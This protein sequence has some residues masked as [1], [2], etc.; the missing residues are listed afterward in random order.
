[1]AQ[2]TANELKQVYP[3]LSALWGVVIG[4][5]VITILLIAFFDFNYFHS[6]DFLISRS[7][8][9]IFLFLRFVLKTDINQKFGI[10]SDTMLVYL[11]LAFFYGETAHFNTFLFPKID[12]FLV[13]CDEWLFGFQPSIWFSAKFNQAIFSELMFLGYFSYYIMPFIAFLI[14]WK[15]KRDFFEEFSFLV[16]SADFVYYIIFILLPA[17]GPQYFF[18]YPLCDI[19]AKGP[20]GA[21]IKLVQHLGEAPTAAFPSSHVG[22]MV[23]I[24]TLLFKEHKTLFKIFVP[25]S[26]TILFST[27]YIKAHYFVDVLAGLLSGPVILLINKYLFIKIKSLQKNTIYVNRN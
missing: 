3:K 6:P 15:Y 24:L 7:I 9:I 18:S 12:P 1:M 20:F 21:I 16:L 11:S 14:I 17:E 25:F 10:L 27:V 4:Y 8:I 5:Q 26:V 13:R 19:D 22:V 2:L 23:I